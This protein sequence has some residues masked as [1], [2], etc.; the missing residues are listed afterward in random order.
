M[1]EYSGLKLDL[2]NMT[3]DSYL[4]LGKRR[5]DEA[6][7]LVQ[8]GHFALG[9]YV[10]GLAAECILS[11]WLVFAGKP[12]PKSHSFYQKLKD[13]P[14]LEKERDEKR[15]KESRVKINS[16]HRRWNNILRYAP[17][18]I[19]ETAYK[20]QR[21]YKDSD[22]TPLKGDLA[23]ANAAVLIREVGWL[24]QRSQAKWKILKKK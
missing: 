13:N 23:W 10:A 22:G 3:A 12:V 18:S 15:K 21:C 19:M 9:G 20:T 8:R 14:L 5:L 7:L 6:D 24:V 17:E 4:Q 16:I 11:G 2:N 1:K